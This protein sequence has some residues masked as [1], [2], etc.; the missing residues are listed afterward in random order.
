MDDLKQLEEL[1]GKRGERQ[2]P[3]AEVFTWDS[4]DNGLL[5]YFSS[6]FSAVTRHLI[7]LRLD[8]GLS[9]CCV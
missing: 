2:T 8:F 9:L 6:H 5:A 1:N 3:Q 4:S 7:G